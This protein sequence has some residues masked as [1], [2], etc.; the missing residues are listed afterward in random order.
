MV[1][2]LLLSLF[3][4]GS[5]PNEAENSQSAVTECEQTIKEFIEAYR[6]YEFDK[7]CKSLT[8]EQ[9]DKGIFEYETE[10]KL[11]DAYMEK[12]KEEPY[13][14]KWTEEQIS[15]Y[16]DNL[17]KMYS[18]LKDYEI[19]KCT[20]NK[21]IVTVTVKYSCADVIKYNDK[22][23]NIGLNYKDKLLPDGDETQEEYTKFI[24]EMVSAPNDFEETTVTDKTIILV[25][26]NDVYKIDVTKGDF[27]EIFA[28]SIIK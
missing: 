15:K 14:G 23:R 19:V 1:T 9:Y 22:L 5:K 10:Q 8:D 27:E 24:E 7:T 18:K 3:G 25:K 17:A 21:D 20:P 4:C 16:T 12:F 26:K 28:Y 2:I 6:N 13:V 11:K